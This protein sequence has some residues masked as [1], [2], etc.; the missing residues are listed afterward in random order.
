MSNFDI[1][2]SLEG[3]LGYAKLTFLQKDLD[4]L[5]ALIRQQWLERISEI[6]PIQ[7]KYFEAVSMDSYHKYADLIDHR[8]AWPKLRRILGQSAVDEIRQLPTFKKLTDQFGDFSISDE[9]NLGRENIYW[10]LVRPNSPSDVG[11]IH[12]DQ[13]FWSLGHGK[14]PKDVQRI[15]VWIAIHCEPGQSGFRLVPGSHLNDWPYHGE[16]K[17]GLLKPVIDVEDDVLDVEIFNSQ[18]GDAIIFHDRLLHGGA[19]GGTLSRVS[20]EFTMFVKNHYFKN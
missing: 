6:A 13:W 15:K 19:V 12:A 1:K 2:N 10:R 14:T 20:L 3:S 5:R 18:P 11:P 9:E 17:D 7:L 4:V 8:Y 16:L